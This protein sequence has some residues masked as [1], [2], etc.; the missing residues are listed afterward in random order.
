MKS[1]KALVL[2]TT[3]L[4]L[5]SACSNEALS[6]RVAALEERVER[7]AEQLAMLGVAADDEMESGAD[8]SAVQARHVHVRMQIQGF[9]CRLED[10]YAS[11]VLVRQTGTQRCGVQGLRLIP[12]RP[13]GCPADFDILVD[14]HGERESSRVEIRGA[15]PEGGEDIII[16][17]GGDEFE[18]GEVEQIRGLMLAPPGFERP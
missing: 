9:A 11:R 2:S 7:Q 17:G 15:E 14:Y 1:S 4:C 8:Y 13:Q 6:G 10:Y 18:C 12:R 5:L 16:T 3:C